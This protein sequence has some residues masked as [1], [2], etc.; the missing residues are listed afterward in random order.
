MLTVD[1][2]HVYWNGVSTGSHF[3]LGMAYTLAATRP[4][5]FIMINKLERTPTKSFGNFL[6]DLVERTKNGAVRI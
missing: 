2:V 3:D 4:I 6:L 1:E 5:K